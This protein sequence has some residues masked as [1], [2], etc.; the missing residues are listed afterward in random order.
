MMKV[1]LSRSRRL[2]RVLL[3]ECGKDFADTLVGLLLMPVGTMMKCLGSFVEEDG[4]ALYN[5]YAS[6]KEID[7]EGLSTPLAK[8]VLTDAAPYYRHRG[9]LL[10]KA[11]FASK[12]PLTDVFI[13]KFR[14]ENEAGTE[15]TG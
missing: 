1:K 14:E 13:T 10:A 3:L 5:L 7:W 8:D 4:N 12:T 2:N 6:M 15:A 11:A 9:L